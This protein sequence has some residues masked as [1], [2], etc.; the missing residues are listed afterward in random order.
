MAYA[1]ISSTVNRKRKAEQGDGPQFIT[2]M[3]S[4]RFFC[5]FCLACTIVLNAVAGDKPPELKSYKGDIVVFFQAE[6]V[7]LNPIYLYPAAK[8]EETTRQ[9]SK[10]IHLGDTKRD[11]TRILGTPDRIESNGK[12]TAWLY[13]ANEVNA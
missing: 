13:N 9:L 4:T 6:Q 7:A 12:S 3:T 2:L 11:V 10:R 1:F 8:F 5:I